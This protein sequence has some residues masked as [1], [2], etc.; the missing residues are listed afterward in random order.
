MDL[1]ETARAQ[2]A[3]AGEHVRVEAADQN[4]N[5]TL[6]YNAD[7]ETERTGTYDSRTG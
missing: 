5:R 3:R 7:F 1:E 2:P 6:G 4:G